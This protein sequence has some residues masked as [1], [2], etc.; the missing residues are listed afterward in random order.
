MIVFSLAPDSV[1][2]FSQEL[3]ADMSKEMD[4]STRYN[5][6][7]GWRSDR[8]VKFMVHQDYDSLT[9]PR[10]IFQGKGAYSGMMNDTTWIWKNHIPPG[11]YFIS[12]WVYVKDD[13]G[14]THEM[15]IF[16]NDPKDGREIQFHH[17][18]LRFYLKTIV[19]G[20][21]LFDLHF[22]VYEPHSDVRIFL[23]KK[24]VKVPFSLDEVLIKEAG[25][26]LYKRSPEWVDKNGF[27][28]KK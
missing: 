2:A 22:S 27:W 21:A 19:N 26:N 11:D 17:E 28:F 8:P 4:D 5:V 20:W 9:S 15:K 12:L 16:E 25:V 23:Q 3:A 18:G 13:M 7:E 6:G 14:M 24:D 10:H 1:R